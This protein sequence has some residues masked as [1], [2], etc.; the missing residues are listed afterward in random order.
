MFLSCHVEKPELKRWATRH[1]SRGSDYLMWP[2]NFNAAPCK[3]SRD[4]WNIMNFVQGSPVS[5]KLVPNQ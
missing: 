1:E 5:G 3:I 2:N 4:D